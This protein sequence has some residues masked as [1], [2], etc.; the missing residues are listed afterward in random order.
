MSAVGRFIRRGLA[1]VRLH[2][3]AGAREVCELCRIVAEM[4]GEALPAVGWEGAIVVWPK[5]RLTM[6]SAFAFVNVTEQADIEL[7]RQH[8]AAVLRYAAGALAPELEGLLTV[9][10]GKPS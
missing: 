3:G 8:G 1:R 2:D 9:P 4:L 5:T 10:E 7:Q 6:A